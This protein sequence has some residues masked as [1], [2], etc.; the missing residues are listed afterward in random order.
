MRTKTNVSTSRN[1]PSPSFLLTTPTVSTIGVGR[2]DGKNHELFLGNKGG[3]TSGSAKVLAG[4]KSWT[5]WSFLCLFD[6]CLLFVTILT[7][8]SAAHNLS[9]GLPP[10][11][12]LRKSARMGE[13][14]KYFWDAGVH[15]KRIDWILDVLERKL[16]EME[17]TG[18]GEG[19][20][21]GVKIRKFVLQA[22]NL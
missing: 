5:A 20:G 8:R 18:E 21:R 9:G 2:A 4:R 7:A 15:L 11:A 14:L 3:G 22:R 1:S 16:T 6:F 17:R 19:V 12:A 13:P 10:F